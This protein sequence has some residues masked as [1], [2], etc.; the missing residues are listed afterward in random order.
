M[1]VEIH[2]ALYV[3]F[4]EQV[5]VAATPVTGMPAMA[6][7]P[8]AGTPLMEASVTGILGSIYSHIRDEVLPRLIPFL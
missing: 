5:P 2:P 3:G 6:V 1:H 7:G 8:F 4:A